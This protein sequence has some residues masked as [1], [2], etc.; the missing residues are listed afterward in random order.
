[1]TNQI[2]RLKT[3]EEKLAYLNTRSELKEHFSKN[4][5]DK[6]T[7]LLNFLSE[8]EFKTLLEKDWTSLC[9]QSINTTETPTQNAQYIKAVNLARTLSQT[10]ILISAIDFEQLQCSTSNRWRCYHCFKKMFNETLTIDKKSFYKKYKI[11]KKSLKG[12]Q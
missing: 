12:I 1:M 3:T 5:K 8:S 11:Y 7:W 2:I 6:Y 9:L 10:G 4:F